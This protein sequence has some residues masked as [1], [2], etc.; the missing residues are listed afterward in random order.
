MDQKYLLSHF[1]KM[2]EG[3]LDSGL[4]G[5]FVIAVNNG[6]VSMS[7]R[8]KGTALKKF[9]SIKRR[10]YRDSVP[11]TTGPAQPPPTPPTIPLTGPTHPPPTH[12]LPLLPSRYLDTHLV[13]ALRLIEMVCTCDNTELT[14]W[15]QLHC[16]IVFCLQRKCLQTSALT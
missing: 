9:E 15:N 1:L 2:I 14:R 12:T 7:L 6:C 8:Q 4:D 3:S 11:P 16:A 13:T 10:I 5:T